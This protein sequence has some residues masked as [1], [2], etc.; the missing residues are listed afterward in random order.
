MQHYVGKSCNNFIIIL[1]TM[2]KA[3]VS[4]I[5]ICTHEEWTRNVPVAIFAASGKLGLQASLNGSVLW[6]PLGHLHS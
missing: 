2:Q 3:L 6:E 4:S 5:K 1:E